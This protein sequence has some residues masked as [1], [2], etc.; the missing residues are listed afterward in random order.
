MRAESDRS[1]GLLS[2]QMHPW[3]YR[4]LRVLP[5]ASLLL[6]LL[7]ALYLVVSVEQET[8]QLSRHALW[9]FLSATV[10]LLLLAAL[11]VGRLLKLRQRIRSGEPGARLTARLIK[12]FSA[13]ALPPVV[14]LYLFALQFLS[15]TVEGW[16]DIQTEQALAE[17]IELGQMFL[18]LRT[19][20]VSQSLERI[21]DNIE[22][23]DPANWNDALFEYV[24]STGPTELSIFNAAGQTQ[25]MV[26]INP[27]VLTPRLLDPFALSQV[28]EN[29][30]YAV[31]EPN[32]SVASGLV[33]RVLQQLPRQRVGEARLILQAIYPLPSEFSAKAERIE[34]AY[35]RYQ[36]VA[37]LR[38]RLE[39][40][41]V[42]ILSLV[43]LLTAL[44]AI[45][46]AF[47]AA[48]RVTQPVKELALATEELAAGRFPKA[49]KST[50]PDELGFLVESFNTMTE[51]LA[52]SRQALESQRRYLE[53]VLSRLSAGVIAVD[54]DGHI[55]AANPSACEIL[56]LDPAVD[57]NRP[58]R[59][60]VATHPQLSPLFNLIVERA[61]TPSGEWRQEIQIGEAAQTQSSTA[62]PLVL[63]CRGSDLPGDTGGHVVVFDD[64][65]VLDQ[66]QREAAWSEVARRLA[67]E[68]KNPLTPIQLAAER[69]EHKLGESLSGEQ[70]ELLVRATSTIGTQVDALRRLVDAFGDYARPKPPKMEVINLA[71]TIQ[72]VIDLY[73]SGGEQATF[74]L[75]LD[76]TLTVIA[77]PSRLRQVFLNLIA[78]A[79]EAQPGQSPTIRIS[80]HPDP[81]QAGQVAVSVADDG[82]GFASDIVARVFEPY[83]TSKAGGTGLGLAIIRRIIEEHGGEIKVRNDPNGRLGGAVVAFWLPTDG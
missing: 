78:N 59:E 32:E 11:I 81:S 17:S 83:I 52:H 3:L 34:Q 19:R 50:T 60:V 47:N 30:T 31:A 73:V 16:L 39:Q 64:V 43:L 65:T 14:V 53:V 58:I 29:Q 12:I 57:Q 72:A 55:T 51:E 80:A 21:V 8:T 38:G 18:D 79:M 45:L 1:S 33:I 41:L 54:Q 82:P 71:N 56:G 44:L 70:A 69:L 63:V 40:S 48:R 20:E 10:A 26:N 28:M 24:R 42:L 2:R 9:V 13:L 76:P 67:H 62:R 5:W 75:D 61:G 4:L 49:L 35:Y 22:L 15:E 7:T 66:A 6:V 25:T 37:F 27:R 77:D 23:D 74:Q 46:L 36:N 68:V